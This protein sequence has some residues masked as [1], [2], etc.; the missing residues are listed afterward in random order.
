LSAPPAAV[1]AAPAGGVDELTVEKTY[2]ASVKESTDPEDFEAYLAKYP[3]GAYVD[4]AQF[5][6]DQLKGGTQVASADAKGNNGK[7]QPDLA[8]A[9]KNAKPGTVAFVAQNQTVYAKGG[10]QV[11]SAPTA[12]A[13]LVAKLQTNTEVAA[14]GIS[15]DEKWWRITL[16]DGRTGY[17]HKSVVSERA[18]QVASAAPAPAAAQPAA[19]TRTL[20]GDASAFQTL[21]GPDVAPAQP[22]TQGDDAAAQFAQNALAQAAQQ[23]GINPPQQK[24]QSAPPPVQT[25]SIAKTP[26]AP[27]TMK[28]SAGTMIFDEPG[29][30]PIYTLTKGGLL[31]ASAKTNDGRWYE[32]ALP[33]GKTGFVARQSLGN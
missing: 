20:D 28:A 13:D 16:A 24:Q 31:L 10:G 19:A 21:G 14:T 22:Q 1:A 5:K 3:D 33:S 30:R 9:A 6:L 18:A 25:A 26:I 15:S 11:R 23:F 17:M 7:K 4:V 2:W 12:D 27:Q 32:V 8:D 29:G